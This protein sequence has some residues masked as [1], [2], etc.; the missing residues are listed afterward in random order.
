MVALTTFAVLLASASAFAAAP[1]AFFFFGALGASSASLLL[2][3]PRLRP[4]SGA[5]G[6]RRGAGT[7]AV[8]SAA[9]MRYARRIAAAVRGAAECKLQWAVKKQPC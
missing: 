6:A 3:R 4:R 2:P 7:N 1:D 8:A 9:T 5:S